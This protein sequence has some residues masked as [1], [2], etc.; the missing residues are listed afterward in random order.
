MAP[1]LAAHADVNALD[2]EIAAAET[3]TRVLQPEPGIPS[4]SLD[5]IGAF[6]EIKTVW[7]TKAMR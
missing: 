6:V 1:W 3:L 7:H 2:L 4:P 5:R